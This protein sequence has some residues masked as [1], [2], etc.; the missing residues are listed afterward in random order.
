MDEYENIKKL[1]LKKLKIDIYEAKHTFLYFKSKELIKRIVQ[2]WEVFNISEKYFFIDNL[3]PQEI[4]LLIQLLGDD[5]LANERI[6]I[7]E[8]IIRKKPEKEGLIKI[9]RFLEDKGIKEAIAQARKCK[10]EDKK[11]APKVGAVI[12]KNKNILV[13]GYRGEKKPGEHAEYTVIKKAKEENEDID[14]KGAVLI[15]TLEPCTTRYHE[16]KPCAQHIIDEGFQKV[17]IGMIDP[18]PDIRGR[19][20]LYLQMKGISVELFS[21]E[22]SNE[23]REINKV[24][25]SD[26][27]KNNYTMDIMKIKPR[28]RDVFQ[29]T[30]Y[31]VDSIDNIGKSVKSLLK[32]RVLCRFM[33]NFFDKDDLQSLSINLGLNWDEIKGDKLSSKIAWLLMEVKKRGDIMFEDVTKVI[34]E[35]W[36][37]Y[38]KEWSEKGNYN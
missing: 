38:W 17:I 10:C 11:T 14:L 4:E 26:I 33:K 12:I 3:E 16:K 25:F 2:Q 19:G 30:V 34:K 5:K 7:K 28:E 18:N 37:D 1:I 24:F 6:D 20:I 22:D 29:N 23:V 32:L 27:I 31:E 9:S 36:P 35:L 13:S 15:T 8:L 21:E